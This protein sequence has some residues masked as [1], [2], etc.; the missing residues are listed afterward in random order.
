LEKAMKNI[1]HLPKTA[2][3]DEMQTPAGLLKI[4]VSEQG[5]H[6]IYWAHES[7]EDI[8]RDPRHPWILKTKQQLDEYFKGS[9][10]IFDLLL[11]P[12]GTDFQIKV[13]QVLREIPHGQAIPYGEQARRL[14]NKNKA[15]AVGMAN[16]QNPIPII[17]PCH[18]VIGA[19]GKLTGFS[20]GL[21][22]KA[23]LLAHEKNSETS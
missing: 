9:R 16:G 1:K 10:K 4:I 5:I 22:N 21:D 18:R 23:W 20:G 15:R 2:V 13:W 12:I 7:I 17:I 11:L 8:S 19:N 6:A 14:G 3:F